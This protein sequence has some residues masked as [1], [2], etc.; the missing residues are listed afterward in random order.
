MITIRVYGRPAPQGSKRHVGHGRMIEMSK[1]VGNW[2]D[3]VRCAALEAIADHRYGGGANNAWTPLDGPLIVRMVFTVAKPKSAP[4]TRRTWPC[5]MPDISKLCRATEDAITSAG[6]WR[7]DARVTEY[8]R[9]AK[10]YPGEDPDAL[11]RPGA[12]IVVRQ[13]AAAVA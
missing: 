2:R 8:E 7:D 10:C 13:L 1:H 12:L 4:K 5:T 9:L 3:D 11:D 6:I